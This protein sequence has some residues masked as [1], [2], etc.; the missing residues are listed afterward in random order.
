MILPE[1]FE[2][3]RRIGLVLRAGALYGAADDIIR[4]TALRDSAI[5]DVI[6][7]CPIIEDSAAQEAE[8][9][10][11]QQVLDLLMGQRDATVWLGEGRTTDEALEHC[12]RWGWE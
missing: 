2:R 4:A 12:E 7:L 10:A 1:I 11:T 6:A 8:R 3:A 9:A 5:A